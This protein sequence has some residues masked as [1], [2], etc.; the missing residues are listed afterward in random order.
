MPGFACAC[1]CKTFRPETDILDVWFE[2]GCSHLAVLKTRPELTWPAAVYLEGHDQ[3]RG[4]FQSSL[5]IGT[6]I[7][8]SAPYKQVVTCGFIINESGEKMSKSRGTGVSPQE[9]IRDSGADILRLWVAMVDYRDDVVYGKGILGR[10]AEAYRKIRNTARY[11]LSNLSDFDPERDALPIHELLD[12][13][14]WALARAAE[15]IERCRRAYDEYEFHVVYHRV[16]DLCTVDL[17]AVYLDVSKDTLY[18]EA[19]ASRARRS[20]QTAMY[21]ILRGIVGVM[22]PILAFTAEEIYEAMPGAKV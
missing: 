5:L 6:G 11:L 7:E 10:A 22:A 17:S 8:G 15:V 3:H 9:V 1:G 12:I 18:C 21:H 4:W 20:A 14:K 19:P 13:D 16:L 2:S